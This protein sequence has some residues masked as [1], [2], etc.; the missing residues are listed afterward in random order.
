MRIT[1]PLVISMAITMTVLAGTE[2]AAQ[3]AGLWSASRSGPGAGELPEQGWGSARGRGHSAPG[4][5]T[6]AAASGGRADALKGRG[7]LAPDSGTTR[8]KPGKAPKVPLPP[9]VKVP[10][11]RRAAP[12]GFDPKASK[13]V[14]AKRAAEARTFTNP[15]GT[16]TTRYYNERVNFLGDDGTWKEVDTRHVGAASRSAPSA[17]TGHPPRQAPDWAR[18][19]GS[20]PSVPTRSA[21]RSPHRAAAPDRSSTCPATSPSCPSSHCCPS[22]CAPCST[23]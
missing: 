18:S 8:I 17:P 15:D 13:E 12:K 5:A 23:R 4:D 20:G 22:P 1:R 7:E 3:A 11:P 9:Y 14:P 2:Q 6:D 16:F 19:A 21:P 10:S